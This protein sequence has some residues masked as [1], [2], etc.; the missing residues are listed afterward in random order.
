MGG[1]A[2]WPDAGGV[3]A[4]AAWVIDAFGILAVLDAQIDEANHPQR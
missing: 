4:Q 2:T 3:A 1:I